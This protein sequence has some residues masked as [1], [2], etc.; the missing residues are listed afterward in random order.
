MRGGWDMGTRDGRRIGRGLLALAALMLLCAR[1]SALEPRDGKVAFPN[2]TTLARVAEWFADGA[3]VL[4]TYPQ[5]LL[6]VRDA[7]DGRLI[8]SLG[9]PDKDVEW[10]WLSPD[11]K[12]VL[13]RTADGTSTLWDVAA[14]TRLAAFETSKSAWPAFS[15]D[16]RYLALS[17]G[18][19]RLLVADLKDGARV[20]ARLDHKGR[21]DT[22]G[23]S[24][25]GTRVVTI[26]HGAKWR[27]D[28]SVWDV[29]KSELVFEVPFDNLILRQAAYTP[30]GKDIVV[31]H[32]AAGDDAEENV[33]ILDAESGAAIRTLAVPG[34]GVFAP[35][36]SR[37]S[38]RALI[39]SVAGG[40]TVWRWPDWTLEARLAETDTDLF[41]SGFG[42]DGR[43]IMVAGRDGLRVFAAPDWTEI[44]RRAP[45]VDGAMMKQ[46]AMSPDKTR[47]AV[48]IENAPMEI[49][50]LEAVYAFGNEVST[51]QVDALLARAE[52]LD[53]AGKPQEAEEIW[54]LV[55]ER[56]KDTPAA[57]T[58]Q[59]RLDQK[60]SEFEREIRASAEAQAREDEETLAAFGAKALA[61]PAWMEG[62]LA[63][64]NMELDVPPGELEGACA[65]MYGEMKTRLDADHFRMLFLAMSAA[66]DKP[67]AAATRLLIRKEKG[68][69]TYITTL[70]RITEEVKS[71]CKFNWGAPSSP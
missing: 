61:K 25:D 43:S 65:C 10:T 5:G 56:F 7:R 54:G 4:V 57:G 17:E 21:L 32:V 23:F 52:A 47:L 64:T 62:C 48:L 1:A 66:G 29:A 40:M 44:L 26:S 11:G 19:G 49:W 30:D 24:P 27:D 50:S 31:V 6:E 2:E 55:R 46:V 37:E 69:Q 34:G 20:A 13:V 15:S 51:G 59:S 22:V 36:F 60:R 53:Q 12:T 9:E 45:V 18:E 39:R 42:P 3:R 14:G 38:G 8:S 33:H 16:G 35:V 28:L 70:Q 68:L 67:I 58:A 41:G 63:G 71:A